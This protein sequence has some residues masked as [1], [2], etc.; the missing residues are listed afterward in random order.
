MKNIRDILNEVAGCNSLSANYDFVRE[1][2]V[3]EAITKIRALL[4]TNEDVF[5]KMPKEWYVGK[6]RFYKNIG[7]SV[8]EVIARF[9]AVEIRDLFLKSLED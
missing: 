4:P 2:V 6:K 9:T 5:K 3:N 8:P 7:Q 1:K